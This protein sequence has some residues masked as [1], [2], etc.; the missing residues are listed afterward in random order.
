MPRT[1]R[2]WAL[3]IPG[4]LKLERAAK[5]RHK[6][7]QAALVAARN[8]GTHPRGALL[9]ARNAASAVLVR[10]RAQVREAQR[11]A[12]GLL[13]PTVLRVSPK[14]AEF[15]ALF[16]GGASRD[17]MFRPYRDP[18]GVWTIG[19]G[20]TAG[21]H[22]GSTPLTRKQATAL[23]LADLNQVYT[24]AVATRLHKYDVVVRQHE[25]DALVSFAYN[26]GP[27][28]LDQPR[29]IGNALARGNRTHVGD[30]ILLYDKAGSPPRALPGLTRRRRAERQLWLTGLYS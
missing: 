2:Q 25:L 11:G 16:E 23:L 18:V 28:I 5:R 20:H 29:T 4:R 10:R 19:F 27:A 21:V 26:L 8:H 17:G 22:A 6:I 7:A 15:I 3:L 1:R 14:G 30:A 13:D 12:L 9:A 24:P